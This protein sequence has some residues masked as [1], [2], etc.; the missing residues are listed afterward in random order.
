MRQ[1]LQRRIIAQTVHGQHDSLE[2]I[3]AKSYHLGS[4]VFGLSLIV[5][6]AGEK[7]DGLFGHRLS[8]NTD[9]HCKALTW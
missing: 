1:W 8:T 3:D 4:I 9:F 7:L 5:G 2:R 6:K